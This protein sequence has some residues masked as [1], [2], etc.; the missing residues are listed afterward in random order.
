MNPLIV[1]NEAAELIDFLIDVFGAT[2]V[3]EARTLDQDG[4]ILHAEL[5]LGDSLLTL[6]DRKPDW[7][8]TPALTRVYVDDVEA[9]LARAEARGARIVTRPT[10]FFGDTLARFQDPSANLWWVYKHDPKADQDWA[11]PSFSS[12]ADDWSSF[13]TPEIEYIH[14]SLVGAMRTLHD[15]RTR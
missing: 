13:S 2:D 1:A 14:G 9:T 8:F 3:P 4:L 10:D 11:E 6:A 5:R 15:P 12:D 7:P